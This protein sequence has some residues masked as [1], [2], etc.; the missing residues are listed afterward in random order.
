MAMTESAQAGPLPHSNYQIIIEP[1][2]HWLRFDWRPLWEYRDLLI[3]MVRRDFLAKYKQTVLGPVWFVLQ[4]LMTTAMFVVVFSKVARMSTDGLPPIL[5]Y[6]CGLLAW[7]YFQQNI[8]A[9]AATFTANAHIFGKVYFPRLILPLST[10]I[11]NLFAFALQLVMFLAIYVYY[12][13]TGV[14]LTLNWSIALVPVLIMATAALSLGVSLWMSSLT[15]KYRD[16]IHLFQFLTQLWMFATPLIYPLSSVEG[17]WKLVASLN[18]MA[19]IVE[20]FRYALL[21]VGSPS[22]FAVGC[23]IGFTLITLIT[24][25]L[26]FQRTER[27]F[28]DTV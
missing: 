2:R 10:V 8:I 16:L 18:P 14:P 12:K 15:A 26:A 20:L 11:S 1:N 23:S 27:T 22:T 4:P 3:L 25:I 21:G 28:I 13:S 5:F 7:N 9:G 24:G 17:K 6:F 19:A